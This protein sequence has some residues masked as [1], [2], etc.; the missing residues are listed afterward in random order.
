M[1]TETK[2]IEIKVYRDK[3]GKPTCASSFIEGS[4]C[5]FFGTRNIGTQEFCLY[6]AEVALYRRGGLGSLIP[7][8]PCPLWGEEMN[9][10]RAEMPRYKCH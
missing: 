5:Q 4:A 1:T 3:N 10:D 6:G 7:A 9:S 2:T 8:K